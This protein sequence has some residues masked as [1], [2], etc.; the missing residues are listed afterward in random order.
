LGNPKLLLQ[1]PGSRQVSGFCI[2]M[3]NKSVIV[4][5]LDNLRWVAENRNEQFRY[6]LN[7]RECD[8]EAKKVGYPVD[9]MQN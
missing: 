7:F 4:I 9:F 8:M 2:N 6:S 5:N 1:N 3:P